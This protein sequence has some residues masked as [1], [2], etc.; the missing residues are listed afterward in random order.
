MRTK[1]LIAI[2]FVLLSWG[3]VSAETCIENLTAQSEPTELIKCLQQ[4]EKNI[5]KEFQNR[6]MKALPIGTIIASML[7]F[8]KFQNVAGNTWKP[9][10]GRKVSTTSKYATLT[11]NTTLPD[12][13][14]MFLRGLNQFDPLMGPRRDKYKDPD[15][16]RRKAGKLQ[17]DA[18]SLPK[19]PFKGDAASAGVHSHIYF[20]ARSEGARSGSNHRASSEASTTGSS[21]DH[22]HTVLINAGGDSETRPVNIA[23]FYY[24]KI[25]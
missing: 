24:I 11:G 8:E 10:D 15:G 23:V 9:A 12:L 5:K 25:D 14:G 7:Q 21:G 20:K 3:N 2:F 18:T 4:L 6:E 13:R 17:K 16:S 19:S 1:L 22:T